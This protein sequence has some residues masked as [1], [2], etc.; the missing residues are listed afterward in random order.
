V[1]W[2]VYSERNSGYGSNEIAV[3]AGWIESEVDPEWSIEH[4]QH[5]LQFDAGAH[6]QPGV[7]A[8]QELRRQSLY[9]TGAHDFAFEFRFLQD[10]SVSSV[11]ERNQRNRLT[12]QGNPV[13]RLN[14]A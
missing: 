14:M 11:Q 13:L 3:D 5:D 12:D 1:G 6:P 7:C 8:R 10:P 9:Q 4:G 2:L